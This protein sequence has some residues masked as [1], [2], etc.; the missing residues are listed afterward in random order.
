MKPELIIIDT[1]QELTALKTYLNDFDYIAY[2]CETTG[3]TKRDQVI[4]FSVCAEESKAFYVILGAWDNNKKT[5]I[6]NSLPEFHQMVRLL[7]NLLS[8]KHL[9]MHNGIFDCMMA[10]AYFN[11]PLIEALHTDTMVLAHLLNENRRIGLKDL[12]YEMF[13]ESATQEQAEM[14]ASVL[15]NSGIWLKKQK[16]MY[17]ADSQILAKYGAKDAWLTFKL[18]MEFVPELD[19]QGLTSFFYDDETMP[20]L[21][22]PTYQLNTTGIQVDSK[23]LSILKKTLEAECLEAKASVLQEIGPRIKKKYPGTSKPKT[24]NMGSSQQLAWL[25]FGE[26]GLEFDSLT[27]GGKKACKEM[28]LKLPYTAT[29]RR[30]FIHTCLTRKGEILVS[31]AIVNGK[32]K[33]AKKIQE[34]WKY[35]AADKKA[36]KKIAGKLEWVAKLLEYQ[37]KTKLLTTYIEGTESRVQYGILHPSYLQHGTKTGRYSSKNPNLMNLPR[38]DQRIK[39]CFVAREGKVFVSADYSQLEPRIFSYYSQDAKLMSAFDGATDFY[40]VIGRDVYDKFD[41]TPQKEG[42]EEAFGVK[43][44]S[45][46]NT[47][48][49]FALA[50]AYGSTPNKLAEITGKP[51]DEI[52]EDVIKYF[53]LFPGVKSQMLEAHEIVKKQGYVTNLFGRIRRIPEAKRIEKLYGKQDHWELPY[54]ARKLLNMAANFRIQSTGASIV[55]RACIA[56]YKAC[57]DLGLDMA[58]ISQIHDEVVLEASEDQAEEISALLQHFMENTTVLKGIK[59][60]AVPRIT[61]T[62]AK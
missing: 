7:L 53:E 10:E 19:K 36:L 16:E 1:L 59:L 57:S 32:K 15:A 6:Y 48:K 37:K 24:F 58:I 14:K 33:S 3:L 29:A 2:D 46:R 44:K 60:E 39:Q 8:S 12:A 52:T 38:D 31:G 27:K 18:F 21:K 22:G 26:Y 34:P 45:L 25:I 40:S 17:K 28:G 4:G 51:V 41:S 61:R 49:A 50:I 23:A 42:S 47:T 13:G 56:L 9:I 43:Y 20:L 35:I 62:L 54:E 55:N 30:A 11:R 5:L